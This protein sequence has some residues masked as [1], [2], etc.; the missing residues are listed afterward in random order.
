MFLIIEIDICI[1]L[2][3]FPLKKRLVSP[4]KNNSNILIILLCMGIKLCLCQPLPNLMGC[5]KKQI[6]ESAVNL[7][8]QIFTSYKI[9][10]SLVRNWVFWRRSCTCVPQALGIGDQVF[11]AWSSLRGQATNQFTL[12][13]QALGL[14]WTGILVT[15]LF[16]V[17]HLELKVW[18]LMT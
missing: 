12:L 16:P 18:N 11:K 17:K 13:S 3:I 2:S 9:V 10:L 4:C 1:S 7:S 8:I 14:V 6:F 5:L 15:Y